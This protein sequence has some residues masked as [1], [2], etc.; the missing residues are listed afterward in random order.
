MDIYADESTVKD[1]FGQILSI[2]S[3]NEQIQDIL[4]KRMPDF[5]RKDFKEFSYI[6]VDP[7][8][9]AVWV[10]FIITILLTIGLCY[11]AIVNDYVTDETDPVKRI[12]HN[13]MS[14]K[15]KIKHVFNS[16]ING[17]R[18]TWNTLITKIKKLFKNEY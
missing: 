15:E 8:T 1:E 12:D 16:F 4:N 7:P 14:G 11:W 17:I 9:W 5:K 2:R 18:E 6:T 10:T 3:S 13:I